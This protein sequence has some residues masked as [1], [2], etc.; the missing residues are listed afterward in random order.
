MRDPNADLINAE[1]RPDVPSASRT[2]L[3]ALPGG[4]LHGRD[5]RRR[6]RIGANVAPLLAIEAV[7]VSLYQGGRPVAPDA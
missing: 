2:G 3:P 6:D 1:L 7:M 4:A 5:P